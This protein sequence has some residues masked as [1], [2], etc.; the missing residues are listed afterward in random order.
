M[1]SIAAGAE[2]SSM[3]VLTQAAAVAEKP[4]AAEPGTKKPSGRRSKL[5]VAQGKASDCE[6]N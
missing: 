4:Q 6:A 3:D 2:D 5:E 1:A